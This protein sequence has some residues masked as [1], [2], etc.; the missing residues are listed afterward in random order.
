MHRIDT[1]KYQKIVVLT[2][3][4]ISAGSGIRTY[5][6]NDGRATD[7]DILKHS[8]VEA[9]RMDPSAV[10]ELYGAMRNEI[11]KARPNPAHRVLAEIER[12]MTKPERFTLI[13]QNVD[14][15]HKVAGSRNVIDMHG[16]I[17]MTRCSNE[18][19]RSKPFEDFNS[20]QDGNV[21]ACITC[22]A[23]LRP[24][25]VLFNEQI[26]VDTQWRTKM[27][28]RDCDLF[29]AI[30]TSG[31]VSPASNFVRSAE[32]EGARTVYVNLT[33]MEPHNPKFSEVYLGRAE[34]RVPELFGVML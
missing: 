24:D 28:L 7:L 8:S 32:Y 16:D 25:I 2:G 15:L 29:V 21:P 34:E 20:Y 31:T 27:A 12:R 33:A 22:G 23:A 5:R 9:L 14:R 4:G 19:C 17:F 30:G 26:P 6:G 3:A 11:A 10:W 18:G 1:T 13:T